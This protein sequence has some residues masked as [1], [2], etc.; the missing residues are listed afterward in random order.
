MRCGSASSISRRHRAVSLGLRGVSGGKHRDA[1][2]GEHVDHG[3]VHAEAVAD[4]DL[5]Q[6]VE[7]AS[8]GL[9]RAARTSPAG[10][11]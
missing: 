9:A 3:F 1:G 7:L 2:L 5:D 11:R 4:G 6:G 8:S 10:V